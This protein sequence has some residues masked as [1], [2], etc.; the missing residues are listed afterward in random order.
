MFDA[1]RVNAVR[2][3]WNSLKLKILSNYSLVKGKC[4]LDLLSLE[5]YLITHCFDCID[6]DGFL[7]RFILVFDCHSLLTW[8]YVYVG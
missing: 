6:F 4:V 5:L 7:L 3:V 1:L 2:E 8:V